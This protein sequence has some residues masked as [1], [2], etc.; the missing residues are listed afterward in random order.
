M[1]YQGINPNLRT[2]NILPGKQHQESSCTSIACGRFFLHLRKKLSTRETTEPRLLFKLLK[3]N[4]R[5]CEMD[6]LRKT[7]I[8]QISTLKKY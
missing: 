8:K 7:R 5:K 6:N 2:D 3:H 4:Q 1:Q